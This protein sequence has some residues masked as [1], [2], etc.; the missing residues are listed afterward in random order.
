MK[1]FRNLEVWKKSHQLTLEIYKVTDGFPK[2]QMYSLISQVQRSAMS[3]EANI[4][5]GCFRQSDKELLR[6]L[7]I[8]GGSASET[9]C[10]LEIAKDLKY[11]A[12]D[13]YHKLHDLITEILKMLSTLINKVSDDVKRTEMKIQQSY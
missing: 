5:E 2:H 4:A 8:A 11:L 7:H 12:G 9:D 10:H 6:F 13:D 3:I 1:N